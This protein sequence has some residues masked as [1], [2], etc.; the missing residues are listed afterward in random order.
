MIALALIAAG[1]LMLLWPAC[2]YNHA[3]HWIGGDRK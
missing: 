1:V 2:L 3:E